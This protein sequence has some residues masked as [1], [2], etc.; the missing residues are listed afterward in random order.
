[1]TAAASAIGLLAAWIPGVPLLWLLV[2]RRR[3]DWNAEI[4]WAAILLGACAGI[5]PATAILLLQPALGAIGDPT[6]QAIALGAAAGLF[7]EA[8]K[9]FV[10]AVMIARHETFARADAR[11]L[12]AAVGLGFGLLE[13]F[14]YVIAT[15]DWPLIAGMR[16]ITAV[17]LHAV[18]GLVMGHFVARASAA[19]ARGRW[20][21]GALLVPALLHGGYDAAV[22]AWRDRPGVAG[23]AIGLAFLT[24]LIAYAICRRDDAVA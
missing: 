10:L 11:A 1:V 23:L 19:P 17:P 8:A 18:I 13:N 6:G 24:A 21:A 9:L 7:E 14:L 5:P 20:L 22:M 4:A 15:G 12:G 3:F 16:A 2:F